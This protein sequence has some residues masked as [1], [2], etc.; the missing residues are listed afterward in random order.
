MKTL[1]IF[2]GLLFTMDVMAGVR[3]GGRHGGSDT[4]LFY[5]IV[6]VVSILMLIGYFKP[7]TAFVKRLL[8]HH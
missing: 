4:Q 7:L 2:T 8:H 3:A 1:F 5:F 6:C